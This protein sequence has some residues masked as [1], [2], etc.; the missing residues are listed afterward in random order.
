MFN[1]SRLSIREEVFYAGLTF[2]GLALI[3]FGIL[4]FISFGLTSIERAKE[5]MQETNI[6]ASL[7]TEGIFKE[8]YNTVEILSSVPEIANLS[9]A[10]GPGTETALQIY[11]R[12]S[13]TNEDIGFIYSGY[14]DGSLLINDYIPPEGYNATERPWYTSAL[15]TKTEQ[16][17]GLPYREAKTDEWL[18]SQSKSLLTPQGK[19]K[20]VLAIDVFLNRINALLEEEKEYPSQQSIVLDQ[21]GKAIIHPESDMISHAITHI[22]ERFDGDHGQF[23]YQGENGKRWAFYNTIEEVDW[24]IITTVERGEVISPIL[25][26]TSVYAVCIA[27]IAMLLALLQSRYFGRRIADPLI[28]LGKSVEEIVDGKPKTSVRYVRS[29]DEIATIANNIQEL[30]ERALQKKTNQLKNRNKK[31]LEFSSLL[32]KDIAQR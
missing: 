5:S 12:A 17:I 1:K 10:D 11:A 6:K 32:R 19:V 8:A 28:A 22:A 21:E 4:F 18:I 13:A 3:V 20:G 27:L 29:N 14:P 31:L 15:K 2:A 30:T 26:R 16:S 7:I 24:N 23:S 9:T 25:L